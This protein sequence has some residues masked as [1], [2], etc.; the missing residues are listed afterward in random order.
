MVGAAAAAQPTQRGR[1]NA[2]STV[3]LQ[4]G[5]TTITSPSWPE[6]FSACRSVCDAQM[7]QQRSWGAG[8]GPGDAGDPTGRGANIQQQRRP[9]T[10]ER[11]RKLQAAGRKGA[12]AKQQQEAN[13]TTTSAAPK[14]RTRAAAAE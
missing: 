9:M 10:A 8:M 13:E 3:R 6:A 14:A 2:Q 7:E 5:L 12:K 4:I 11:R 1:T